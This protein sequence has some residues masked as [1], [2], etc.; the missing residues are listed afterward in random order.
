MNFNLRLNSPKLETS[1]FLILD[2]NGNNNGRLDSGE[3][4]TLRIP[5]LNNG[6]AASISG[7]MHLNLNSDFIACEYNTLQI[8]S[9]VASDSIFADFI[10]TAAPE[11]PVGTLV[12]ISYYADLDLNILQGICPVTVGLEMVRLS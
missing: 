3:T 11:T 2:N 6:H 10:I 12:N 4:A 5:V 7:I 9:I 8:P 1:N